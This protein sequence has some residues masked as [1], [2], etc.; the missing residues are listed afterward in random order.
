VKTGKGVIGTK[1]KDEAIS[2]RL[3]PDFLHAGC[4]GPLLD[5]T[6]KVVALQSLDSGIAVG[7]LRRFLNEARSKMEEARL[8]T[9]AVAAPEKKQAGKTGI[10]APAP[11]PVPPPPAGQR[12]VVPSLP[13]PP[14]DS[15]VVRPLPGAVAGVA[16]GGGGRFLV[17]HLPQLRQLAIFD[18][19]E[20]RVV[21]Y[22]PLPEDSILFA[23]GLDRLF[24]VLPGSNVI[25]RW[26]LKT[27]EREVAAPLPVAGKITAACLGS[28]SPGPLLLAVEG[29]PAAG[30]V[31]LDTTT[32]K[33]IPVQVAGGGQ[34]PGAGPFL[35]ASADGAT[36]TWRAGTLGIEPHGVAVLYLNGQ[37]ATVR[38]VGMQSS[39]PVPGPDGRYIYTTSG[40]YTDQLVHLHPRPASPNVGNPFVPAHH[41]SF[42]LRLDPKPG[43]QGL[44]RL[45]V[46]VAG[47]EEPFAHLEDVEG[48]LPEQV[49]FGGGN[50]A[51]LT[52]DQ[53]VHFIPDARLIVTVSAANDRLILYR[54]DVE[55]A[56]A[57]SGK[58]YLVVTSQPPRSVRKGG[59]Y[60]YQ[61]RGVSSKGGIQYRLDSGPA[62]MTLGAG[63]ELTWRVPGD[64]A[65]KETV[66]ITVV[67]DAGKQE[68]Y[69]PFTITVRD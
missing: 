52:P 34:L 27:F 15:K 47:Q 44:G 11:A 65:E 43:N 21:K 2:L 18:A 33:P 61:I 9:A 55:Q 68:C 8:K 13:S 35:H 45:F 50:A 5:N 41:G 32:L 48:V 1:I 29:G 37:R 23:A 46:Y 62:G 4:G 26:N 38:S 66:V 7:R 59:T 64:H 12:T 58:D 25:Q 22:L 67:E 69:H 30:C 40:V 54:F 16:V 14:E 56:L 57:S 60:T 36:F 19:T 31:F 53:R 42:F 17:L 24:V 10:N 63:G 39:V 49:A 6:G 3:A 28:A 51:K 20:A